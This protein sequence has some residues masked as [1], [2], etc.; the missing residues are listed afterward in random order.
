MDAYSFSN[1][2]WL[3]IL[4]QSR[5]GV[6]A[7]AFHLAIDWSQPGLQISTVP[8]PGK[9]ADWAAA[10]HSADKV[11]SGA[12]RA[13]DPAYPKRASITHGPLLI[14][15]HSRLGQCYTVSHVFIMFSRTCSRRILL[16]CTKMAAAMKTGKR[17]VNGQAQSASQSL[18]T[19]AMLG[20]SRLNETRN[21][22]KAK[23]YP[24][25]SKDSMWA[26]SG[27]SSTFVGQRKD[28]HKLPW[29]SWY[30]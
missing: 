8:R 20:N 2:P 5:Q 1:T 19:S 7:Q 16:F 30:S 25:A 14:N 26:W 27:G 11:A 17:C 28:G 24:R 12:H 3:R 15:P 10:F 18:S 13:Y 6:E 22:R 21:Q 4:S 23:K 29:W 9:E